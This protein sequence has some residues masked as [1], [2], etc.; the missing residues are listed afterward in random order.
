MN[1][2]LHSVEAL[3]T[4]VGR[5]LEVVH[6]RRSLR[7]FRLVGGGGL[8]CDDLPRKRG[9]FRL[10]WFGLLSKEEGGGAYLVLTRHAA[11]QECFMVREDRKTSQGPG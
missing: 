2:R 7:R 1:C 8:C 11:A 10:G 6:R 4:R 5:F 9:E 3:E